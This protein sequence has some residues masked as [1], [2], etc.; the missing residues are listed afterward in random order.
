MRFIASIIVAIVIPFTFATPAEATRPVPGYP[1]TDQCVNFKG[2]QP[3]WQ[4]V[5]TGPYRYLDKQAKTC[6]LWRNTK[7]RK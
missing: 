5:G 6:Y 3:A 2:L 4:L 7:F 1:Y